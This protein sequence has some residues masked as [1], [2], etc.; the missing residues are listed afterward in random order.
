[1]SLFKESVV[2]L[3]VIADYLIDA[4]FAF[5]QRPIRNAL[6]FPE[7]I[8]LVFQ[9]GRAGR[10]FPL[11]HDTYRKSHRRELVNRLQATLPQSGTRP[12]DGRGHR[13]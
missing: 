11:N 8:R 2:R 5:L 7:P 10:S 12:H 1:M 13:E 4:W 9:R 6:A 3:L